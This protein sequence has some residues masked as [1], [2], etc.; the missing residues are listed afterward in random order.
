MEGTDTGWMAVLEIGGSE[1]DIGGLK[2][3]K[4]HDHPEIRPEIEVMKTE[5]M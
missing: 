4:F 2:I 1:S 5:V 3:F